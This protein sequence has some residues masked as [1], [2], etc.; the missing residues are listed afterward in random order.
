[1]KKKLAVTVAGLL[2]GAQLGGHGEAAEPTIEQLEVISELIETG[3]MEA[4][5]LFVMENPDLTEGDD[6]VA[7]RLRDFMEEAQ[8]LSA[9]LAFDPPLRAALAE[10][11]WQAE[12]SSLY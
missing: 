10:G 11:F 5:I 9:F 4:L 2:L 12:G 3:D 1:M 7:R 6:P 8:N